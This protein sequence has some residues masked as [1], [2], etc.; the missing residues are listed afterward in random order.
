[1]STDA[2]EYML[3]RAPQAAG[4]PHVH[5]HM[6]RHGCGYQLVNQGTNTASIQTTSATATSDT[7]SSIPKWTRAAS[8]A[9]GVARVPTGS[10]RAFYMLPKSLYELI[11][12]LYVVLGVAAALVL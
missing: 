9:S 6:L 1:M 5:P 8:A 4:L 11:P 2:V 7:P 3:K 10:P 12:F